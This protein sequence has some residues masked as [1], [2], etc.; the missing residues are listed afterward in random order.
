MRFD[1]SGPFSAAGALANWRSVKLAID[2]ANKRGGVLGRYKV[3]QVDADSQSKA[4][5]AAGIP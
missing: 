3:V 5:V 4:A 2:H 1:H